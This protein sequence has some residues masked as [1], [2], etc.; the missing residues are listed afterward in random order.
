MLLFLFLAAEFVAARDEVRS[1]TEAFR[2]GDYLKASEAFA[3]AA[4]QN[5]EDARIAYNH[6]AALAAAG[7]SDD[8]ATILEKTAVASDK[9]VAVR[10]LL[11]L[12]GTAVEQARKTLSAE[13]VTPERRQEILDRLA[14]AEKSYSEI[15]QIDPAHQTARRNLEEL[16]AWRDRIRKEWLDADLVKHRQEEI[17]GRL[18][19]LEDWQDELHGRIQTREAEPDSPRKFQGL[20][21]TGKDQRR[22]ADELA[23]LQDDLRQ[24]QAER[25][26]QGA[27]EGE[28]QGME[29]FVDEL[30]SLRT[31]AVGVE[32]RLARFETK[33]AMDEARQIQEQLS[34]ARLHLS[35]FE[36]IV[37]EA[38]RRQSALCDVNPESGKTVEDPRLQGLRDHPDEQNRRQKAVASWMPLMVYRARQ[39]IQELSS[40]NTPAP[41]PDS[42]ED[43]RRK[44]LELAIQYG[45]KIAELAEDAADL[46]SRNAPEVALPH[47]QRALELIREILR[48][49]QQQNQDQQNQDQQNRQDQQTQDQNQEGQQGEQDQQQKNEQ[50]GEEEQQQEQRQTEQ[51]QAESRQSEAEAKESDVKDTEDKQRAEQL[52]RQVKRRQQEAT[53]RRE[54]I[55]AMLRQMEPVEKDW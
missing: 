10:S 37:Q 19:W 38:E 52:L 17:T 4:E 8:A 30:D 3:T 14:S 26:G 1:A 36:E 6:A 27:E 31:K 43:A 2:S 13:D 9:A 34:R 41:E 42:P 47:Q 11:L 12:G 20:Y 35:S 21:E 32:D 45:P 28:I 23:L 25:T 46:L 7:K 18:G 33:E 48:Q 5:P 50:N 49:E 29:Q 16:R 22:L 44:S 24:H 55:R 39:A 15:L 40:Q 51:Q 54:R 53:D